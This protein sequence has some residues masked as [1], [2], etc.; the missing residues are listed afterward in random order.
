MIFKEMEYLPE[1]AEK[2]IS[3]LGE[4]RH[5][6]FHWVILSYETHPCAYVQILNPKHPLYHEQYDI[7]QENIKLKGGNWSY[8]RRYLKIPDTG[9]PPK[10][11][12]DNDGWWIGWDYAHI[13]NCY[14]DKMNHAKKWTTREILDEVYSV[15][16]QLSSIVNW[17][18]VNDRWTREGD[19]ERDVQKGIITFNKDTK[20]K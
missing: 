16:Y 4:G 12:Q 18:N 5:L 11:E 20:E 1:R 13:P 17:A 14:G 3:L 10:I 9:T 8:S 19:Y 2:Q 15:I 6:G 7:I